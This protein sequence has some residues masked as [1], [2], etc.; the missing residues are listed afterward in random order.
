MRRSWLLAVVIVSLALGAHVGLSAQSKKGLKVTSVQTDLLQLVGI[1]IDEAQ[2]LTVGREEG[3]PNVLRAANRNG[4][5]LVEQLL[6]VELPGRT[7]GEDQGPAIRRDGEDAVLI[8]GRVDNSDA[9]RWDHSE[10]PDRLRR[11]WP[12]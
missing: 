4:V 5:E 7:V 1:L 6:T 9:G 11:L 3:M 10:A 12:E 2:P 8:R